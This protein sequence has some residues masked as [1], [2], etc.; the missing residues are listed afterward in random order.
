MTVA[1]D[2]KTKHGFKEV[3]AKKS[4]KWSYSHTEKNVEEAKTIDC[5]CNPK[6]DVAQIAIAHQ[7]HCSVANF[8]PWK[9]VEAEWVPLLEQIVFYATVD[10]KKVLV[11]EDRIIIP[12]Y[13]CYCTTNKQYT[14]LICKVKRDKPSDDWRPDTPNSTSTSYSYGSAYTMKDRHYGDTLKFPDGTVVWAS[15]AHTR[16]AGEPKPDFGL[17]LASSW[18][19]ECLSYYI[20]WTDYGLPTINWQTVIFAIEQAFESAKNG[21][22]VEVGCVGGHGRTGTVL[23]CMATIAGVKATNAVKWVRKHYCEHA[24]ES[25]DQ[26]WFVKWFDCTRRGVTPPKRPVKKPTTT[27]TY[28]SKPCA[29][30]GC[31]NSVYTDP[32]CWKCKQ[33]AKKEEDKTKPALQIP[34]S[35]DISDEPSPYKADELPHCPFCKQKMAYNHFYKEVLCRTMDCTVD[36][37]VSTREFGWVFYND[38]NQEVAAE[39]GDLSFP[40]V[41]SVED[42]EDLVHGDEIEAERESLLDTIIRA[43]AIDYYRKSGDQVCNFCKTGKVLIY[44]EDTLGGV[45]LCLNDD[46]QQCPGDEFL[47]QM[48]E[49]VFVYPEDVNG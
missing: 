16:K 31:K 40:D 10:A 29:T 3:D 21:V 25:E 11:T 7:D 46:C 34:E 8:P 1:V 9:N 32:I 12:K 18:N 39:K 38:R 45:F 47:T 27:T 41:P 2:L 33:D 43:E 49:K 5:T 26:K 24:V 22:N 30:K 13:H 19:P 17:Y 6:P 44:D 42:L 23:A 48:I 15:S 36:S 4:F 37:A 28:T 20:P 35:P 14:C